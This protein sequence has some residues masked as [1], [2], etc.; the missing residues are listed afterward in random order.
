[1][2]RRIS[3][4]KSWLDLGFFGF[5]PSEFAKIGTVLFMS[6]FLSRKNT[7]LDNFKD[8]VITLIIGVIPVAL[9]LLEP[10]MGTSLSFYL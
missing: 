7:D 2:G 6:A 5:Q 3:G 10:D 4:A 8:I 1:M 9:I